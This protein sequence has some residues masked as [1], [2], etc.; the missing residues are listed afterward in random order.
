MVGGEGSASP[1]GHEGRSAMKLTTG[2]AFVLGAAVGDF[3]AVAVGTILLLP[4]PFSHS[5]HI[6]LVTIGFWL[7]PFYVL[8]FMNFVHSMGAVVAISL[9]ANAILF[10]GIGVLARLACKLVQLCR[11]E[12]DGPGRR[13]G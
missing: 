7:C 2:R 10:G 12:R 8:M 9:A 13:H 6:K 5:W 1:V 11:I 4:F 3:F